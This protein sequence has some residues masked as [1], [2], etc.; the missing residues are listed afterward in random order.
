M[1]PERR[2]D[3]P[4]FCEALHGAHA[5]LLS[6]VLPGARA[7]SA[8]GLREATRRAYGLHRE[9]IGPRRFPVRVWNFIP[10]ITQPVRDAGESL[11]RYMAFNLGRHDAVSEWFGGRLAECLPA[12]TGVGHEGDALHVH[13]LAMD[14][15]PT[16]VENPRQ[17]PA[18]G[19]SPR[20]GPRPPCFARASLVGRGPDRTL[21]V[22]G[23]ASILGEESLHEGS[24]PDQLDETLAN[25][26]ALIGSVHDG[27]EDPIAR[28]EE[29]RAYSPEPSH[30][31]A[32]RAGL[33]R[34]TGGREV[35]LVRADL[36]RA[37]LLVEVEGVV[38]VGEGFGA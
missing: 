13:V 15:P 37:E 21:I 6:V 2:R 3:G 32:I 10:G 16:P 24:L 8:P 11:D 23:T 33:L 35:E 19:Y 25:L 18:Y 4:A 27:P 1:S 26:R 30:D 29:V 22:A 12:A 38:R 5:S 28:L 17:R 14:E 9:L 36:C 7:L 34:A 31:G 20:Y